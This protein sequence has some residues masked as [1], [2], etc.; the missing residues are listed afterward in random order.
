MTSHFRFAFLNALIYFTYVWTNQTPLICCLRS[1]PKQVTLNQLVNC[2]CCSPILSLV[3][4]LFYFIFVC[5][6]FSGMA[7]LKFHRLIKSRCKR[8]SVECQAK[9]SETIQASSNRTGELECHENWRV[10][11]Y[12]PC[13][14]PFSDCN[15]R[16]TV[17]KRFLGAL[18]KS[19]HSLQWSDWLDDLIT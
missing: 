12:H 7:R 9:P 4:I 1:V 17:S 19:C 8:S 5:N 13:H 3:E 6:Y 16:I 2:I 15:T 10:T 18:L 14:S 11:G